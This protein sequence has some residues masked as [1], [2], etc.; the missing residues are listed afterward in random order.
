MDKKELDQAIEEFLADNYPEPQ[1]RKF[2]GDAKFSFLSGAVFMAWYLCTHG[3]KSRDSISFL[4]K[5]L[6]EIEK[7]A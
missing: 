2:I 7:W 4:A 5:Q 3:T 6:E 1:D